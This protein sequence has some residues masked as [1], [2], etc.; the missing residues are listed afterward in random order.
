MKFHYTDC[1]LTHSHQVTPPS[2]GHDQ[3]L[4]YLSNSSHYNSTLCFPQWL[5][6]SS[7]LQDQINIIVYFSW[8]FIRQ[9]EN[10]A[11]NHEPYE[12]EI[13]SRAF[14]SFCSFRWHYAMI[15]FLSP[16]HISSTPLVSLNQK[17]CQNANTDRHLSW[18]MFNIH[19]KHRWDTSETPL[20]HSVLYGLL[21]SL[22][23]RHLFSFKTIQL[24]FSQP[25]RYSRSSL[26]ANCFFQNAARDRYLAW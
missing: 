19:M 3:Q 8:G 12:I 2:D 18:F 7:L 9:M 25:F 4:R 11:M 1:S 16:W 10:K 21:L 20:R 5:L 17:L 26:Y 13:D 14:C 15:R 22:T 6:N 23:V 24:V